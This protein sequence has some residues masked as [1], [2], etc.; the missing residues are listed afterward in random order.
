MYVKLET[1]TDIGKSVNIKRE[2]SGDKEIVV[3]HLKFANTP[4][5]RE[6]FDELANRP[7]GWSAGFLFDEFGAPVGH[8]D[9]SFPMLSLC[10]TGKIRGI[11][12]EEIT[13]A[14][15]GLTGVQF[16]LADKGAILCG[17]LTWEVAGDEVSDLEPLIGRT[18]ILA[19][20]IQDSGQQ[21]MLKAA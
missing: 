16:S 4:V 9:L 18:C 3:A 13:L 7:I 12:G 8:I 19:V 2:K 17:E 21:D 20:V 11:R 1:T 10:V 6:E 5:T 14:Q 15:A